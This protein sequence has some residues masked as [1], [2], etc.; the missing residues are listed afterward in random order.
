MMHST[1]SLGK[2][3]SSIKAAIALYDKWVCHFLNK[4]DIILLKTFSYIMAL[5][6]PYTI[7]TDITLDDVPSLIDNIQDFISRISA[8]NAFECNGVSINLTSWYKY[9]DNTYLTF[10]LLVDLDNV[11][12]YS[13]RIHEG[14]YC[15]SN[16]KIID[17]DGFINI[18][19]DSASVTN[20]IKDIYAKR[21]PIINRDLEID[22]DAFPYVDPV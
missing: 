16:K 11:T 5:Y 20:A 2:C 6:K 15:S 21:I 4:I 8:S 17:T 14:V 19:A 10:I 12:N 3:Q 18:K 22:F 7:D 9:I 1:I 13:I